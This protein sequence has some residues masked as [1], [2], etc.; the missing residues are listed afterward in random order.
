[1]IL[2]INKAHLLRNNSTFS[3][4]FNITTFS[5]QNAD[6][7]FNQL[8]T[9]IKASEYFEII[10]LIILALILMRKKVKVNMQTFK[11]WAVLPVAY[12]GRILMSKVIHSLDRFMSYDVINCHS[13]HQSA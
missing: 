10:H 1:M 6:P 5:F 2:C 9:I 11:H 8:Y 4:V 3:A 12:F 7:D 13:K